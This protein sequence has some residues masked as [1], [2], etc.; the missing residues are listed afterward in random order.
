MAT[1]LLTSP[2]LSPPAPASHCVPSRHPSCTA[3]S[4]GP[5]D[6]AL[7]TNVLDNVSGRCS[8]DS[9]SN[10]FGSVEGADSLARLRATRQGTGRDCNNQT[11]NAKPKHPMIFKHALIQLAVQHRHKLPS[12]YTP[13]EKG[14]TRPST[15]SSNV[16]DATKE[17]KNLTTLDIEG[18][19][20]HVLPFSTGVAGGE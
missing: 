1:Y 18:W 5:L 8:C 7:F 3:R 19:G 17:E 13:V 15:P 9:M 11:E 14:S 12:S 2:A 10:D 4:G 16:G 20:L 6:P